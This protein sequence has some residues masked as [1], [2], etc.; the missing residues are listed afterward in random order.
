MSHA[1]IL[2][3]GVVFDGARTQSLR[4]VALLACAP[5]TGRTHQIRLHAAHVG[6]PLLGDELYGVQVRRLKCPV[7][8]TVCLYTQYTYSM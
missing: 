2:C 3:A 6:H 5:R 4:G 7:W 1:L 8:L